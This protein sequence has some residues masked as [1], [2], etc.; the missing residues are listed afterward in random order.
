MTQTM[1]IAT[2]IAVSIS[3]AGCDKKTEA[4][5]AG[6]PM[7]PSSTDAMPNMATST[8]AKIGKA[9]GTVIAIDGVAGKITLDHNAIPAVG[10]PPMKMGFTADPK[11][12]VGIAVGDT[13]A[14][15]VT[16]RDSMGEVTAIKKQ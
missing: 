15:E 5:T 7:A 14:F 9:T 1:K 8:R 6:T 10:W 12:L 2:L 16:V 11:L 3:L 13:V 4:S